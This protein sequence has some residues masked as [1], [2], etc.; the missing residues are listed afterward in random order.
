[1]KIA[2]IGAGS[3]G[4]ALGSNYQS[5]GHDVIYG[6]R[7]PGD[8]K[9]ADISPQA[10]V[11]EAAAAAEVIILAVPWMA[12]EETAAA[13]GPATG[14]IVLDATNPLGMVEG[15][16]GLTVGHSDS[17]GEI[18]QRLLPEAR[19]VKTLNQIGAEFMADASALERPPVMFLASDHADAKAAAT[20]LID[21]LGFEAL[22]AGPLRNARLL[23]A[24][25]MLWI[26]N[27]IKG[28]L[29]REF[30]FAVARRTG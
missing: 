25:A 7:R 12:V 16:L 3:V 10:S 24:F 14:K 19:V 4:R 29:G 22:D 11:E 27:A 5:A 28:D 13:I 9:Y 8:D 23:E 21:A 18:V 17:G 30:G 2:I 1:M 26:W 20:P 6:V 15:D